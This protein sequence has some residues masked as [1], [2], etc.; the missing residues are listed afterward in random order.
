MEGDPGH[1]LNSIVPRP[2][3]HSAGGIRLPRGG[4]RALHSLVYSLVCCSLLCCSLIGLGGC[5]SGAGAHSG[6]NSFDEELQSLRG[7]DGGKSKMLDRLRE[8]NRQADQEAKREEIERLRADLEDIEHAI[9]AAAARGEDTI[10]LEERRKNLR[11]VV[12]SQER[13]L[14]QAGGKR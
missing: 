12:E 8:A 1:S 14:K 11:R 10:S 7:A 5:Q 4:S 2:L 6:G 3:P 9:A 13:M